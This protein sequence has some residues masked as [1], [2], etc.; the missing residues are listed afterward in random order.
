MIESSNDRQYN[1]KCKVRL[2]DI[3]SAFFVTLRIVYL[4]LILAYKEVLRNDYM[5][6]TAF[7]VSI[8]FLSFGLIYAVTGCLMTSR[9]K[10]HFRGFYE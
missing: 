10:K 3:T 7:L 9:L 4:G 8:D 5:D 6:E 1:I 2:L